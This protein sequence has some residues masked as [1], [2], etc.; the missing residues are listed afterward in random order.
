MGKG[1]KIGIIAI[2]LVA[3]L[4]T[5]PTAIIAEDD[6]MTQEDLIEYWKWLDEQPEQEGLGIPEGMPGGSS[7]VPIL[8]NPIMIAFIVIA[9][10]AVVVVAFFFLKNQ[11]DRQQAEIKELKRHHKEEENI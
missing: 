4:L 8:Y 5:M 10:I 1:K 7:G 9:V 2:F 11:Q 6:E 3:V